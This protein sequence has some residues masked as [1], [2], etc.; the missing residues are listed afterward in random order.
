M[1]C[2]TTAANATQGA[3]ALSDKL[4]LMF[5]C[6]AMRIAGP[7]AT[8]MQAEGAFLLSIPIYVVLN[9]SGRTKTENQKGDNASLPPAQGLSEPEPQSGLQAQESRKNLATE[10]ALRKQTQEKPR[11]E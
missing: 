8:M 4:C 6:L 5:K 7:Q 10:S 3:L 2:A 9:P 1:A 11:V